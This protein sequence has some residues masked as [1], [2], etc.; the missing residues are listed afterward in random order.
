MQMENKSICAKCG[1]ECCKNSGCDFSS[2]DF[3]VISEKELQ[4]YMDK[5]LISIGCDIGI[6]ENNELITFLFV[7]MRNIDSEAVDF[8]QIFPK[9]CHALRPDGCP[10][11][12]GNRP[13]GGK[14]LIP[15]EDKDCYSLYDV[16]KSWAPYQNILRNLVIKN[17]GLTPEEKVRERIEE[18]IYQFLQLGPSDKVYFYYTR[19]FER[20]SIACFT[21]EV[22]RAYDRCQNDQKLNRKNPILKDI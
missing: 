17:T 3:A 8:C 19:L 14:Y 21:E 13:S 15:Q 4:Q 16:S 2:H 11:S 12:F 6:N 20:I 1:G 10:Y 5:G 9:P 22:L 18:I 7:K